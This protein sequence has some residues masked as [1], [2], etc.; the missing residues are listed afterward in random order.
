MGILDDLKKLVDQ[1]GGNKEKENAKVEFLE[2]IY[3]QSAPEQQK[4]I[5][6]DLGQD[7]A[8][9]FDKLSK[10]LE[11]QEQDKALIRLSELDLHKSGLNI[12]EYIEQAFSSK[13]FDSL[14][15]ALD[16]GA[17]INSVDAKGDSLLHKFKD[18]KAA[19]EK[20]LYY[21]ADINQKDGKG[22]TLLHHFVNDPKKV[23]FL[24][25]NGADSKITNNQGET[26]LSILKEPKNTEVVAMLT[27][28]VPKNASIKVVAADNKA[29]SP[30]SPK[31][32][33]DQDITRC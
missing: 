14:E 4:I 13:D 10:R 2:T 12:H 9:K 28:V 5:K 22:E 31:G 26:A 6:E 19:V 16:A 3:N 25:K 33:A 27:A 11:T 7:I 30:G 8:D 32:V 15:A 20:L 29:K 17:D 23:K 24:L 21:G 18:S 1:Y